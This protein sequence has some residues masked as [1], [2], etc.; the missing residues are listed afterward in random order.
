LRAD[1]LLAQPAQQPDPL[2]RLELEASA[3]YGVLRGGV[4]A[5]SHLLRRISNEVIVAKEGGADSKQWERRRARIDDPLEPSLFVTIS[6]QC[7]TRAAETK[8][9]D[10]RGMPWNLHGRC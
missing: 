3:H 8:D 5:L 4:I 2:A 1:A 7:K 9:E 10:D 6:A